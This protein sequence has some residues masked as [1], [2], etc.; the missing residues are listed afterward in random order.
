MLYL[1]TLTD[2][3]C[4][5]KAVK[6]FCKWVL[7]FFFVETRGSM[8]KFCGE[9]AAAFVTIFSPAESFEDCNLNFVE[10]AFI[11]SINSVST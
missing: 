4:G 2:R 6:L 5:L 8:I 10:E 1:W 9:F 3:V 7:D 11:R